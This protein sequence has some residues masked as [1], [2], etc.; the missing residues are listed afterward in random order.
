MICMTNGNND[1]ISEING[2][3]TAEMISMMGGM[4]CPIIEINGGSNDV[5][6]CVMMGNNVAANCEIIGII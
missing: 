2:G 5:M 1:E 3:S 6:S 4:I